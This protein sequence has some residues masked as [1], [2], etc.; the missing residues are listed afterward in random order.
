M[1]YESI[2]DTD[3]ALQSVLEQMA[4]AANTG[5]AA[6]HVFVN[7]LTE[8]ERLA[9]ASLYAGCRDF[10]AI[11]DEMHLLQRKVTIQ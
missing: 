2:L 7:R 6:M 5:P 4:A 11:A 9:F 1:M 10:V 3:E 8:P